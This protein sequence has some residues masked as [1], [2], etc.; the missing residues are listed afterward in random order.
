METARFRVPW[1]AAPGSSIFVQTLMG[2]CVSVVLPSSWETRTGLHFVESGDGV[3]C[4]VPVIRARAVD[5]AAAPCLALGYPLPG[6]GACDARRFAILSRWQHA[7]G[8]AAVSPRLSQSGASYPALV[9][10]EHRLSEPSEL[11]SVTAGE[12]V[13]V[14]EAS[15][16]SCP[17]GFV[18]VMADDERCAYGMVP[19]SHLAQ[20][21]AVELIYDFDAPE[22]GGGATRGRWAACVAA[23]L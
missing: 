2:Q 19:D 12:V 14:C 9:L 3:S 21:Q 18:E 1:G 15:R 22:G 10:A 8:L 17:A 4:A 7:E 20:A 5:A 6:L 16:A 11:P 13:L 23:A